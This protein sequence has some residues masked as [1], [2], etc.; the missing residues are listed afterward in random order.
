MGGGAGGM[1]GVGSWGGGTFGAA[2]LTRNVVNSQGVSNAG[3]GFMSKAFPGGYQGQGGGFTAGMGAGA[4][5]GLASLAGY[6]GIGGHIGST[7]G[8]MAMSVG[9]VSKFATQAISQALGVT[10]AAA[11]QLANFIVPGLGFLVGFGM[12]K[13]LGALMKPGRIKTDK[14]EI[15]AFAK[16]IGL[17][18]VDPQ[19]GKSLTVRHQQA[20]VEFAGQQGG[21]SALSLMYVDLDDKISHVFGTMKRFTNQFQVGFLEAGLT[22]EEANQKVLELAE[23][24]GFQIETVVKHINKFA[25]E[26]SLADFNEELAETATSGNEMLFL[27]DMLEGAIQIATKFN[28]LID[29]TA[30]SNRYLADAFAEAAEKAGVTEEKITSLGDRIRSGDL[31]VEKAIGELHDIGITS[32]DIKNIKLDEK[33]I[34]EELERAMEQSATA[35]KGMQSAFAAGIAAGLKGGDVAAAAEAGFKDVFRKALQEKAMAD[36]IE[37]NMK[38]WFD[39]FDFTQPIDMSSDA[40]QNLASEIGIAAD[41]LYDLLEAAGLLPDTI[42]AGDK[43]LQAMNDSLAQV[44]QSII[45]TQISFAANLV[46]IGAMNAVDLQQMKHSRTSGQLQMH[47]DFNLHEGGVW[48]A[49]ESTEQGLRAWVQ[50]FANM[51]QAEVDMFLAR[52]AEEQRYTQDVIDGINERKEADL[53]ANTLNIE[54]ANKRLESLREERTEISDIAKEAK[55]LATGFQSSADKIEGMIR[56]IATG[57]DAFSVGEQLG[58]LQREEALLRQQL[59]GAED[60]DQPGLF[61]KLSANLVAQLEMSRNQGTELT[62]ETNAT[63]QE[64][65]RIQGEAL[66]GATLQRSIEEAMEL[67]LRSIDGR[68]QEQTDLLTFYQKQANVINELAG[69]AIEAA[70]DRATAAIDAMRRDTVDRLTKLY[71][72]EMHVWHGIALHMK[73]G[74]D[75]DTKLLTVLERLDETIGDLNT[76]LGGIPGH[77]SGFS[78]MVSRPS[79]MQVAERGPEYVE[80]TPSG[81]VPGPLHLTV[82]PTINV[83]GGANGRAVGQ[84]V[85]RQIEDGIIRS[86]ESGR[87]RGVLKKGH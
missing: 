76:T 22:M 10:F 6:K 87:L 32:L 20:D 83:S 70:Q 2:G 23:K 86:M 81:S 63:L 53:E 24:M 41:Q 31:D 64:L 36:F 74:T 19:G 3:P 16:E 59:I 69:D 57:S 17:E 49:L 43:N 9:V 15:R 37:E 65:E 67:E 72:D 25:T 30:L 40:F 44:K 29:A 60:E 8:A 71:D 47:R 82:A 58:F 84:Q 79:L 45:D 14:K 42:A 51:R 18:G 66:A 13:L 38:D 80:V 48:N 68:I 7:I 73:E 62:D 56:K 35:I 52:A 21:L 5:S 28:P 4:V 26:T 46:A 50:A 61:N 27:A 1:G 75:M 54:A 12:E 77:A 11:G 34:K 55:A 85:Y 78:G 39:G 33:Q